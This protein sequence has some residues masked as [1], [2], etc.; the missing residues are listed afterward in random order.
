MAFKRPKIG[1]TACVG[2]KYRNQ[3]GSKRHASFRCHVS[4]FPGSSLL[5]RPTRPPHPSTS[6]LPCRPIA[7]LRRRHSEPRDLIDTHTTC[8]P[9]G[10]TTLHQTGS[11][12]PIDPTGSLALGSG[13][14]KRERRNGP[15]KGRWD[16]SR[17]TRNLYP[18]FILPFFISR[19][20]PA[21]AYSVSF[22]A[23]GS[24]GRELEMDLYGPDG[25]PERKN[26]KDES[27]SRSMEDNWYACAK[28]EC[29]GLADNVSYRIWEVLKDQKDLSELRVLRSSHS[30]VHHHPKDLPWSLRASESSPKTSESP[31]QGLERPQSTLSEFKTYQALNDNPRES[32][33]C[34][35]R[36]P[37][38]Q[39]REGRRG[40]HTVE[41]GNGCGRHDSDGGI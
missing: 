41:Q 39:Q 7:A 18:P 23:C 32:Y 29:R 34:A 15:G 13:R 31:L 5:A 14:R 35:G 17:L 30:R 10:S 36:L 19:M 24:K 1:P 20:G 2:S 12:L 4:L 16:S 9:L 28:L 37:P 40:S 11:R 8:S 3:H 33:G 26:Q 6:L 38:K 21:K 27:A 22:N 25:Q